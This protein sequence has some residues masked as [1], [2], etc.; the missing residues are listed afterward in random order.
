MPLVGFAIDRRI[1]VSFAQ[2]YRGENI[3]SLVCSICAEIHSVY[4]GCHGMKHSTLASGDGD[5]DEERVA[6]IVVNRK[7]DI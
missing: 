5:S 2:R 3:I 1:T 6:S 4:F 7:S